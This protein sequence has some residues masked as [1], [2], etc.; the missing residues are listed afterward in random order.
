MN[1]YDRA[2]FTLD[3]ALALLT[4]AGLNEPTLVS[5][6]LRVSLVELNRLGAQYPPAPL[7]LRIEERARNL[8]NVICSFCPN[9]HEMPEDL[10]HWFREP[11]QQIAGAAPLELLGTAEGSKTVAELLAEHRQEQGRGRP[12]GHDG[13]M[14]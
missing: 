12:G 13:Q 7:V 6:A 5:R 9:P 4:L 1:E 8:A 14:K 2:V 11:H 3:T 10:R